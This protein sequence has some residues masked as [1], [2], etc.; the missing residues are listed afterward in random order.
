M[1]ISGG[2]Q[3]HGPAEKLVINGAVRA[4]LQFAAVQKVGPKRGGRSGPAHN[5]GMANPPPFGNMLVQ[6]YRGKC[7]S[8]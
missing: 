2:K 6:T 5:T 3:K 8:C 7:H 4:T 1:W